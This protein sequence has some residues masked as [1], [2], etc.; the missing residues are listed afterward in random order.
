MQNT[1]ETSP[2]L[3]ELEE[4]RNRAEGVLKRCKK[5][6]GAMD[7]YVGKLAVE[8]IPIAMLGEA[9]DMYDATEAKWDGLIAKTEKEILS[10]KKRLHEEEEKLSND[11]PNKKL[12]TEV[13]VNLFGHEGGQ[14]EIYLIYGNTYLLPA[15]CLLINFFSRVACHLDG[16][17]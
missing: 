10:I 4:D 13:V 7:A 14:A 16:W 1:P 17:L 2:L 3:E 8:H 6:L 12:R 5:V 15:V 9:M 11:I